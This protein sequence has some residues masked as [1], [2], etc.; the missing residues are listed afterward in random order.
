MGQLFE[1]MEEIDVMELRK[2]WRALAEAKKE[3]AES[4]KEF[5]ESQKEFEE[6]QKEFAE[7]QKVFENRQRKAEDE[8]QAMYV[9][10]IKMMQKM[11]V[12]KEDIVHMLSEISQMSVDEAKTVVEKYWNSDI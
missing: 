7:S 6:S 1:N 10:T 12:E 8:R 9:A 2:E 4:Q 3:F 5:E 11:A